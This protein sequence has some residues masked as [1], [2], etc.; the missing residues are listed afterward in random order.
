MQRLVLI[1]LFFVSVALF[2]I[3]I[4]LPKDVFEYYKENDKI[5]VRFLNF[6]EDSNLCIECK[7]LHCEK[8]CRYTKKFAL[9][10]K[11]IYYDKDSLKNNGHI[12]ISGKSSK[13]CRKIQ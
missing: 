6:L 13:I 8:Y 5:C 2:L 12:C 11:C 3:N 7:N 4:Y 1:I 9:F 10:E